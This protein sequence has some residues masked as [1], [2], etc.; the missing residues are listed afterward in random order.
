MAWVDKP[1]EQISYFDI[2]SYSALATALLRTAVGLNPE[3][4]LFGDT[5]I[6]GLSLGDVNQNGAGPQGVNA[7]DALEMLK[8]AAGTQD[9]Q[10]IIDYIENLM[11]PYMIENAVDYAAY[12]TEYFGW[13]PK[14]AVT[15]VWTE[16]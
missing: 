13:K 10:A 7:D 2:T 6:N 8:Y 12:L 14:A 9:D 15:T 1:S 3:L 5:K 11:V 16:A 4:A